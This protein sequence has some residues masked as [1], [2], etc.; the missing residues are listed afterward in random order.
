MWHYNQKTGILNNSTETKHFQCYSGHGEGLNNPDMEYMHDVGPIPTG[1]YD[2]SAFVNSPHT[3]PGTI[4]LN[5]HPENTM[6]GR[7][8]FRIHGDNDKE[9]H[10]ASN[11]CIVVSPVIIRKQIWD[12]ND[13][14]LSVE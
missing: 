12:S 2:M 13:L 11:G 6:Y 5:P 7:N 14:V 4:V 9:D 3:G 8:G 10:S 1:L